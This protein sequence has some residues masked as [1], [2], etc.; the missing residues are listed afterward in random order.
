MKLYNFKEARKVF[1][2]EFIKR[3]LLQNENNITK[4]AKAIKVGR[5]YLHKKIKSLN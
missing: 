4:T 5:S 1:E 2:K 3:K